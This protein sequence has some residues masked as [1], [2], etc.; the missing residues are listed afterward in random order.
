[1]RVNFFAATCTLLA[2]LGLNTHLDYASAAL[3]PTYFDDSLH[4]QLGQT[5][6]E[7]EAAPAGKP[8]PKVDVKKVAA[9]VKQAD[10]KISGKDAAKN[11]SAKTKAG[12]V[13]A[14]ADMKKKQD[15]AKQMKAK[16]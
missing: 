10:A 16:V 6:I 14:K 13:K 5:Y 12:E 8:K 2:K 7:A 3:A 9:K 11:A 4:Y 15:Q 1:M